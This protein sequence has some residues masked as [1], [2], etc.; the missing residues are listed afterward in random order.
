[1]LFFIKY[2]KYISIILLILFLGLHHIYGKYE[3]TDDFDYERANTL[4]KETASKEYLEK[5]IKEELNKEN[6]DDAQMYI[7][8]SKLVGVEIDKNILSELE[9]KTTLIK[10]SVRNASDFTAGVITGEGDSVAGISG[11]IASDFMVI[12]DIRDLGRETKKM[13]K[14]EDYDEFIFGLSAI[15]IGLTATTIGSSGGTLP[16][17]VGSSLLKI[18]K[19]LGYLSKGLVKGLYKI[20]KKTVDLKNIKKQVKKVDFTSQK[21]ISEFSSKLIKYIN[22][23]GIKS[24]FLD[25]SLIKKS[26]SIVS[27]MHIIKY[28]KNIKDVK[29]LKKA[30]VKFKDNTKAVLKVVG[31]KGIKGVVK[32]SKFITYYIMAL[33]ATL[34]S[35]AY[36][37]GS[38]IVLHKVRKVAFSS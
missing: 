4:L 36:S 10:K 7:G 21:S 31:I 8:L 24:V 15:G 5:H 1:M 28:A 14:G 29:V 35:W 37:L 32:V 18:S 9:E 11:A 6:I 26:T 13:L 3:I 17:K 12:G 30:A 22:L 34:L 27:A 2:F 25:L 16:M 19:K 20:L 33:I 23:K 38:Y